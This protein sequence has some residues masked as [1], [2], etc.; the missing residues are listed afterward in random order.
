MLPVNFYYNYPPWLESP[1]NFEHMPLKN[2]GMIK[3]RGIN[4]FVPNPY[5]YPAPYPE[6]GN[7][8]TG[9]PGEW[10]RLPLEVVCQ[11]V[12]NLL[13]VPANGLWEQMPYYCSCTDGVEPPAVPF[14]FPMWTIVP[15]PGPSH[16]N[17][18]RNSMSMKEQTAGSL[19]V[20]N[21]GDFHADILLADPRQVCDP[22]RSQGNYLKMTVMEGSPLL[23]F[24][25]LGGRYILLGNLVCSYKDRYRR[26][27]SY[28]GQGVTE[29]RQVGESDAWYSLIYANQDDPDQPNFFM[30]PAGANRTLNPSGRQDNIVIWAVY[31]NRQTTG[32]TGGDKPGYQVADSQVSVL[33][34]NNEG[35]GKNYFVIAAIPAQRRYPGNGASIDLKA[36]HAFAQYLGIYAFNFVQGSKVSYHVIHH[37]VVRTT[38]SVELYSP[39]PRLVGPQATVFGLFP[40]HYQSMSMGIVPGSGEE[41]SW[42][43]LVSKSLESAPGPYK[44]WTPL[45]NI[46]TFVGKAFTTI[47][48]CSHLLPALPPLADLDRVLNCPDMKT[49]EVV[50][51]SVGE[52]L[53]RSLLSEYREAVAPIN[54]PWGLKGRG[55][56]RDIQE[57]GKGVT[58][59]AGMVGL[60]DMFRHEA[61]AGRL[62]RYSIPSWVD[63]AIVPDY[64]EL[65]KFQARWVRELEAA[66][67]SFFG[68]GITGDDLEKEY[69]GVYGED[70]RLMFYPVDS[71]VERDGVSSLGN[72][73][74]RFLNDGRGM[75]GQEND[76][77]GDW[78]AGI[79]SAALLDRG[80]GNRW[81]SGDKHDEY[82]AA[83]E[84]LVLTLA[85]DPD[86]PELQEVG[87]GYW[88]DGTGTGDQSE[89]IFDKFR[90]FKQYS[91]QGEGC[92]SWAGIVLWG[93]A[94]NRQALVDMGIY[95]LATSAYAFNLYGYGNRNS[96][97]M[98]VTT[99]IAP[100]NIPGFP[101]TYPPG[102][103]LGDSFGVYQRR[104]LP[105]RSV[106]GFSLNVSAGYDPLF[107]FNYPP[108]QPWTLMINRFHD[109]EKQGEK[110]SET[111]WQNLCHFYFQEVSGLLEKAGKLDM[112]ID[113][114]LEK[115]IKAQ[116]MEVVELA[117]KINEIKEERTVVVEELKKMGYFKHFHPYILAFDLLAGSSGSRDAVDCS[118]GSIPALSYWLGVFGT[119]EREPLPSTSFG[120]LTYGADMSAGYITWRLL[121]AE[122]YGTPDWTCYGCSRHGEPDVFTA[123][124]YREETVSYV[125]FN[126]TREKIAVNFFRAHDI[127]AQQPLLTENMLVEPDQ[128]SIQKIR[129]KE[130]GIN[131]KE[132]NQGDNHE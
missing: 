101:G 84:Q 30:G 57:I 19:L 5:L 99:N 1:Y 124:F 16:V 2:H 74:N 25:S 100:V 73:V 56:Y 62:K 131:K 38:F 83:V 123:A 81:G 28:T 94:T 6:T 33:E 58:R 77:Y 46:E 31:W 111:G 13:V 130:I 4:L 51:V 107:G 64:N 82:G 17:S 126:G 37:R 11:P 110:S 65:D 90:G 89:P 68:P 132:D 102:T 66:V 8:E 105:G 47:H 40:H 48:L 85:F 121:I 21:R 20:R 106:N 122:E 118:F 109:F 63:E 50:Q 114:L 54:G 115:K 67:Q 88:R 104:G 45:G 79:G 119:G 125:A 26:S 103:S 35:K 117:K 128:W 53:W 87:K 42:K 92:H 129:V 24:E 97:W 49:G 96:D 9:L 60:I 61:K 127:Q 22:V 18:S 36:A 91:G 39:Y 43:P 55:V 69:I 72:R 10:A 3:S 108:V 34:F 98:P 80:R 70:G 120:S 41:I 71:P 78:L 93:A 7:G 116:G 23:W 12:E 27:G 76:E 52:Y 14:L 75:V 112:M 59:S 15:E 113:R 44:Y 29:P 86:N 32:F 95:L